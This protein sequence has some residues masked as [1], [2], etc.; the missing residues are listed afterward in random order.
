MIA[1]TVQNPWSITVQVNPAG[2]EMTKYVT[3]VRSRAD[4]NTVTIPTPGWAS[5]PQGGPDGRSADCP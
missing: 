4:Q 3:P 1:G 5:T 2:G